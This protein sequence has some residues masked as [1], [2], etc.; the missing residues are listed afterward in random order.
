MAF[1]GGCS[2]CTDLETSE[3]RIMTCGECGVKVHMLCYGIENFEEN[4][5]CSPCSQDKS[6]CLC[7]LCLQGGGSMK[8]TVCN[9]WVHVLCALFTN[10]VV[11]VDENLMEPV[12]VSKISDSKRNRTCAFCLK[13]EGFCS[14]CSSSK[15]KNRLH[16]TC[17]KASEC[18]KEV[19]NQNDGSIK[20][21]AYCLD[22]KP[23]VC[24]RRISARFVRG[25]VNEKK[26]RQEKSAKIN[27]NWI[28]QNENV[29]A[30]QPTKPNTIQ[31]DIPREP[32]KKRAKTSEK[33]LDVVNSN[34]NEK[35]DDT[36]K[37]A[38]KMRHDTHHE[39]IEIQNDQSLS[40]DFN[41]L[42]TPS[43][44]Q[45]SFIENFGSDQSNKENVIIEDHICLKD[46]E[47]FKV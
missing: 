45:N 1:I 25:V 41:G 14:L 32:S 7:V 2:V 12:D 8:R 5:K 29:I 30:E 15:C 16:I 31:K 35:L 34:A 20:F 38:K 33:S 17:A 23:V 36:D 11:F 10:D 26:Q 39:S 40:W 22:H 3:N 43:E 28:T 47:I 44:T 13:T 24:A 42:Q 19:T 4:W 37:T 9:K 27:A 46:T 21:R 18:L 6:N